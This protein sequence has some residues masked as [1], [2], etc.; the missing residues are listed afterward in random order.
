MLRN[1]FLLRK[2][3][4]EILKMIDIKTKIQDIAIDFRDIEYY[5]SRL[6]I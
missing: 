5:G 4:D 6:Q 2:I 3:N 1:F